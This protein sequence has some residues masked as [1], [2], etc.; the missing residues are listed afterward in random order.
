M[1][2]RLKAFPDRHP[3]PVSFIQKLMKDNIGMLASVISWSLFTSIVPIVLGLVAISGLFMRTAAARRTVIDHLSQALQG[4]LTPDDLKNLVDAVTQN[5]GLLG[6]VGFL[7]VLWGG[8]NVGGAIS[9]VF[10]P[11]FQTPARS[12]VREK[13]I[14]IG[15]IFVF[16][17]LMLII[18]ASTTAGAVLNRLVS[19][20]PLTG[21][22][23]FV[24]GTIIS[25]MAAFLLFSVIY[26]VFP[27][28]TVQSKVRTVWRGALLAAVLFQLLSYVWPL[29]AHFAHFSRYGAVLAPIVIL[30][31]WI[32]FFSLILLLGAEVVAFG[33]QRSG[34]M[35]EEEPVSYAKVQ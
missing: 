20:F 7:G 12:F 25:L 10:Q 1:I 3:T 13:L 33:A 27:T 29:Y 17:F 16:T 15:M 30:A 26:A 28:V 35:A 8:S 18:V 24:I 22:S 6:I 21:Y 14:D 34:R 9:T 4:V 23:S 31:A 2:D 32:Y 19:G 5:T 11:I